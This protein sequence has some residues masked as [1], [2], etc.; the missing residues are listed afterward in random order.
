LIFFPRWNGLAPDEAAFRSVG[1]QGLP[2]PN[3]RCALN[4]SEQIDFADVIPSICPHT[5]WYPHY[6]HEL[7]SCRHLVTAPP[8]LRFVSRVSIPDSAVPCVFCSPSGPSRQAIRTLIEFLC[9]RSPEFLIDRSPRHEPS[10]LSTFFSRWTFIPNALR[11]FAFCSQLFSSR[12][13][14]AVMLRPRMCRSPHTLRHRTSPACCA[15]FYGDGESLMS[16]ITPSLELPFGPHEGLNPEKL[17]VLRSDERSPRPACRVLLAYLAAA[18][19]HFLREVQCSRE[20]LAFLLVLHRDTR[21]AFSI[22]PLLA[23]LPRVVVP[24]S[25]RSELKKN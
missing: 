11:P 10:S 15:Y 14:Y 25:P 4:R 21:T 24:P 5:C 17:F 12:L 7:P 22:L 1:L 13:L 2:A 18:P 8:W 20:L 6:A 3:L 9:P 16:R 19:L 23:A